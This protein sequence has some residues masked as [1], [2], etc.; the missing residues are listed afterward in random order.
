MQ[1][2]KKSSFLKCSKNFKNYLEKYLTK[3]LKWFARETH[4]IKVKFVIQ[5]CVKVKNFG[6]LKLLQIKLNNNNKK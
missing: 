1:N 3:M 5:F 2:T 4:K 6:I